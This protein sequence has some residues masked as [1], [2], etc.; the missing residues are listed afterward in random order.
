MYIYLYMYVCISTSLSVSR[1]LSSTGSMSL[2][3]SGYSGELCVHSE[4][5][6]QDSTPR[7]GMETICAAALTSG[8]KRNDPGNG[9]LSSSIR[10]HGLV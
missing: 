1:S 2:E 4:H 6:I 10:D 3:N 9:N 8:W 5:L 7:V